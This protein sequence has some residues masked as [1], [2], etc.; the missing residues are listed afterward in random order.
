M[1]FIGLP[2][3]GMA[4]MGIGTSSPHASANLEIVSSDRGF[5][6]PRVNLT[7]TSD[8]STITTPATGLMV[9]NTAT[10]GT[11]PGNVTPGLYYYDG[12]KWQRAITQQPD[13]TVE[14]DKSTP[15]TAGVVFT[16]NTPSSK[17]VI[18]VSTVD[19]SQWVY[20]GTAY[21]T[22]TAPASTAWYTQN[23]T[24]DAGSNKTT[25]LYRTG[26][27]GIG[28]AS[29]T[30][31]AQVDIRASSSGTGL[32]LVDASE[33]NGKILQSDANG[34]A[35]WGTNVTLPSAVMGVQGVGAQNSG[36]NANTGA[37]IDLPVGKWS[38]RVTMIAQTSSSGSY[39]L[40][41]TFESQSGDAAVYLGPSLVGGLIQGSNRYNVLSGTVL[42]NNNTGSTK[43][44]LYKTSAFGDYDG[45]TASTMVLNN[46][47]RD[48]WGENSIVAYPIN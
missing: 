4:Q 43:R 3:S 25:G 40:R 34:N 9:Y 29:F 19:A 35:S 27:L 2:I 24:T 6:P 36:Q 41:T 7:G 20:N 39:W 38:V 16:P 45:G 48:Q 37:Y 42:I 23:S 13:A 5:L 47:A 33:G 12:S 18:Y 8:V 15:T 1:L 46:F 14:F 21:V 17:D 22:Y 31:T 10:A 11:A 26:K 30:P 44:Y 28:T 32:R